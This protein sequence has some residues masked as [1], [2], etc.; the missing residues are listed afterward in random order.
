MNFYQVTLRRLEVLL[1]CSVIATHTQLRGSIN[2]IVPCLRLL[3]T[4]GSLIEKE[5]NHFRSAVI[6][7]LT[8]KELAYFPFVL[9]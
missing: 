5:W 7:S 1:A 9:S 6:L 3:V 4:Y 8:S 2:F